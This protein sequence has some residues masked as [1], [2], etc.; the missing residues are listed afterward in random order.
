MTPTPRDG[1]DARERA[2]DAS[3]PPPT[4]RRRWR[5]WLAAGAL[6]VAAYA[7][8]GF[9][10]APRLLRDAL[11]TR[12]SA[13]LH[14]TVS[15]AEVKVNPFTLSVAV[16]GLEVAD[17]GSPRLAGWDALHVRL[18]PWKVLHGDVGVAEIR[19]VRP[20]GRVALDAGG[21]LNVQDLLEGDGAA[22]PAKAEEKEPALGV[23]LDRLEIEDARV[24][25]EDATRS[26]RFE[27]TVGPLTIRLSD[28]RTRGGAD[29]RYAFTGTTEAG[30]SFSWSG[31]VLTGPLRSSGALSFSGVT[32]PKYDPYSRE[33]APA[34]LVD[35]GKVSVDARYALE[36]G[37][38]ARRLAVTDLRVVVE[39]LGLARRRD[40]SEAL[41]VPRI[42]LSG[43][44]LD[45]VGRVASVAEVKVTGARVL[46]RRAADG[47]MAL[48]E[49]LERPPPRPAPAKPAPEAPPWTWSVQAVS[50]EGMSV[51]A[52]DAVPPR[53][54]RL[55]LP[56]VS[57][58]LTGLT[59]RPD[60][61]CPLTA[62]IRWGEQG[63]VAVNGTVWPLAARA[64]LQI[65]AEALDLAP[66]GPYLDDAAPLRLAAAQLGLAARATVDARTATPAW[67]FSGDVRLDGLSLRH[68]TR[69]E[70][71]LRWRSLELEGVDVGSDARAAV[72]VV[73]LTEPRLRAEI[74][75]WESAEARDVHMKEAA[76]TGA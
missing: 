68:P 6:I 13:A 11:R 29:S 76:A 33:D 48:A 21:R 8:F 15:V 4:R 14:R 1:P 31:T 2:P 39:D 10:L 65:R 46:P 75:D 28:F 62:S 58:R 45:L 7:L 54:V 18:A 52:E 70:E 12:G 69:A 34:L 22:P 47:T 66:L 27:T 16:L 49:M 42:E 64:D 43:G 35:S 20:F 57:A 59:G 41:R 17:R 24:V 60:V 51:E 19:L 44:A 25:F 3:E 71:V 38:A 37:T 26:P 32:L 30:E 73:R 72:K 63:R 56:E 50:I 36:W 55:V 23:A 61:A 9:L 53:P 40:R 67:T 5:R 74:A